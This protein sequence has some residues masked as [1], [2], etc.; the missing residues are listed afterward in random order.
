MLEEEAERSSQS[1]S[2]TLK[3]NSGEKASTADF[4]DSSWNSWSKDA[5][6][7]VDQATENSAGPDVD[8][9]A[10]DY[11]PSMILSLYSAVAS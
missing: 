1:V 7:G 4:E 9:D 8:D 3:N 5:A 6:S 11:S 2:D 10:P